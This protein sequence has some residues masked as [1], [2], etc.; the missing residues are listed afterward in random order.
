MERAK[1]TSRR[2]TT[3]AELSKE[4]DVVIREN[5]EMMMKHKANATYMNDL[6]KVSALFPP[7]RD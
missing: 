7:V 1:L 3:A 6:A 5:K 2:E 4:R